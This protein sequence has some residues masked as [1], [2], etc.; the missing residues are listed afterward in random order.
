M[1]SLAFRSQPLLRM[2][3]GRER[4]LRVLL[5]VERTAWRLAFEAA[6][7]RYGESFYNETLALTPG[8]LRD[9]VLD[10]TRVLD[11]GCG[12]G[13]LGRVLADRVQDYLGIDRNESQIQIARAL[14]TQEN[15]RFI[16]GDAREL[17]PDNTDVAILSHVLEHIDEP[18]ELLRDLARMAH[19]LVIEVPDFARCPL[20]RARLDLE[21]DFS[22]DDDHVREYTHESLQ[23]QL[24]E[25]G[26]RIAAW[27]PRPLA[28]LAHTS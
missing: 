20:N 13:R 17:P 14:S 5:G 8:V 23:D 12:T 22:T 24:Q 16:V 10:G 18:V 1:R 27:A 4:N 15:L 3:I 25:A 2:A 19:T 21:M 28:V 11:V 9:W 26:W 6:G 7:A